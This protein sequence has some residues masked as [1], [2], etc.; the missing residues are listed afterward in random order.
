MEDSLAPSVRTVG[1][2]Y[3]MISAGISVASFLLLHFGGLGPFNSSWGWV[4]LA[5][6]IAIVVMAHKYF[7]DNGDGFMSFGQGFGMGFWITLI[8]LAI[9][10]GFTYLFVTF[11]DQTPMDDFYQEQLES[12]QEKGMP[13]DQIDV[14][15]EWTRKLFWGI[16]I[17]FGFI[18]GL[19]IPLI[20]T[21]FT[22]KKNP[23]GEMM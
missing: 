16:A 22:Q 5:I 7:K 23:Q 20:V 8:S 15:F 4:R 2:R 10:T 12:M 18:F 14:A 13:D 19:L 1:I 17:V 21:I 11:I 3:G 9:G 6:G